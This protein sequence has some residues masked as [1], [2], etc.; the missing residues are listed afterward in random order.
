MKPI[1]QNRR[2]PANVWIGAGARALRIS[3]DLLKQ[4]FP[5]YNPKI[6]YKF[7]SFLS[8]DKTTVILVPFN[9]AR[10]NPNWTTV[11]QAT[12]DTGWSQ[13]MSAGRIL[14][15]LPDINPVELAKKAF[16]AEVKNGS[17]YIRFA[18]KFKKGKAA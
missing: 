13:W 7:A 10:H 5:K 6:H 2:A 12:K 3:G 8:D 11:S 9:P 4:L 15:A 16:P 1:N 14:S 18:K 17:L